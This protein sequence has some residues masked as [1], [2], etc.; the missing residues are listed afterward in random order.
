MAVKLVTT[1]AR[2]WTCDVCGK[3]DTWTDEWR[4]FSS[5]RIKESCGC[6]V[7]ACSPECRKRPKVDHLIADLERDHPGYKSRCLRGRT[8]GAQP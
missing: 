5:F 3:V 6:K 2:H 8:P 7:V 4:W 1:P